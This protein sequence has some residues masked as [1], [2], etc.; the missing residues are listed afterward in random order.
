MI[1]QTVVRVPIRTQINRWDTRQNLRN[2]DGGCLVSNLYDS[3][4][5]CKLRQEANLP[6]IIINNTSHYNCI[7]FFIKHFILYNTI[8]EA[9]V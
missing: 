3:H 8:Y 9:K 2:G 5:I 6:I 7:H 4:A 1:S